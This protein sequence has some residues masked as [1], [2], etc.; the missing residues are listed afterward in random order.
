MRF[1]HVRP[2]KRP[3]YK[4]ASCWQKKI[5]HSPIQFESLGYHLFIE[6]IARQAKAKNCFA[7]FCPTAEERSA[8]MSGRGRFNS[9]SAFTFACRCRIRMPSPDAKH[10][11]EPCHICNRDR[12]PMSQPLRHRACFRKH[13]ADGDAGGRSKPNHRATES[14]CISEKAPIVSAL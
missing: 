3:L 7:E 5:V 9:G 2:Q 13:V 12:P 14:H 8:L 4:S 6:K 10:H 11:E 1:D